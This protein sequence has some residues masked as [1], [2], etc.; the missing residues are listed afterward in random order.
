MSFDFD[1]IFTPGCEKSKVREF[2]ILIEEDEFGNDLGEFQGFF[3]SRK[4][5]VMTDM[6]QSSVELDWWALDC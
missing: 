3:T 4:R 2:R 6:G 1:G 5:H